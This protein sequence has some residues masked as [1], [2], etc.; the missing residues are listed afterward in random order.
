MTMSSTSS[1]WREGRESEWEWSLQRNF[2][3]DLGHERERG[4]RCV[5]KRG[6]NLGGVWGFRR[7]DEEGDMVRGNGGS[8]ELGA[9]QS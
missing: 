4:G 3:V 1:F 8:W 5:G 2:I 7:R 6:K 9:E